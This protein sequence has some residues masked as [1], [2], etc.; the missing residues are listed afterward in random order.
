M[1]PVSHDP[2]TVGAVVQVVQR[3]VHV[4]TH[5]EVMTLLVLPLA[6]II[7]AARLG[8]FLFRCFLKRPSVLGELVSGMLIG[9]Y[10]FGRPSSSA[11]HWSMV[12]D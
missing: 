11:G 1:S 2:E 10:A 6:L 7:I 9:P 12:C 8:G 4:H 3:A 5:T